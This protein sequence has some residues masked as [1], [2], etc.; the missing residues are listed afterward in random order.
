MNIQFHYSSS[1]VHSP[2][3][4][5]ELGKQFLT[6]CEEYA[7][8]DSPPWIATKEDCSCEIKLILELTLCETDEALAA[9]ATRMIEV[10]SNL[11]SKFG[12]T[13]NVGHQLE[14]HL[15]T[16]ANGVPDEGLVDEIHTAMNVARSLSGLIVDDEF[17]DPDLTDQG[18]RD[19]GEMGDE[20]SWSGLF[21]SP[22]S[23]IRFR[24]WE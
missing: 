10:L 11:S 24:E 15:G 17:V 5:E 1:P 14:P 4:A 19:E 13:W 9:N 6:R 22:D 8:T 16:I 7:L 3:R 21:E 18:E 2:V 12:L 20:E 23:F